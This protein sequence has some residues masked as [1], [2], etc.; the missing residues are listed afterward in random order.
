MRK[1]KRIAE[2]LRRTFDEFQ[3]SA[4][5]ATQALRR[6]ERGQ[7]K[8]CLDALRKEI[9]KAGQKSPEL[10]ES[11]WLIAADRFAVDPAS[12]SGAPARGA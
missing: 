12:A 4:E 10:P 9:N 2:M 7:P 8:E 3:T 1:D 6:E 5:S 11:L